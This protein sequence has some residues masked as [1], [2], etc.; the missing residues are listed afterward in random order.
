[1][2][3]A[4]HRLY[5]NESRFP[6]LNV[7]ED[8]TVTNVAV[9]NGKVDRVETSQG[10]FE[11]DYFINCAGFWARNVGRKSQPNVRVPL[12]AAKYYYLY[13]KPMKE[14]NS[15]LPGYIDFFLNFDI[16]IKYYIFHSDP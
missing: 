10:D 14:L 6:G 4:I 7:I 9:K 2:M 13:T 3:F 5:H 1:M 12:Y 15:S 11:C 8:C 16:Q